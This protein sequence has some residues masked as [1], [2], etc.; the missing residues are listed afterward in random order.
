MSYSMGIKKIKFSLIMPI[1]LKL[2]KFEKNA[3]VKLRI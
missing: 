1:K 3:L 2:K